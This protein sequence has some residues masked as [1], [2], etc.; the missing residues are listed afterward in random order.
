MEVY[1][2]GQNESLLNLKQKFKQDI[3]EVQKLENEIRQITKIE[4]GVK[5]KILSMFKNQ[6]QKNQAIS[7]TVPPKV[8]EAPE[9]GDLYQEY[10]RVEIG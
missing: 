7:T 8:D 4:F 10:Q 5:Q 2:E 1:N 6:L 3:K 9:I